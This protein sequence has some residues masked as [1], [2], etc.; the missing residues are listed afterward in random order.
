MIWKRRGAFRSA[1]CLFC[2]PAGLRWGQ[3]PVMGGTTPPRR[4][5]S[6]WIPPAGPRRSAAGRRTCPRELPPPK[7]TASSVF[8]FASPESRLPT[9]HVGPPVGAKLCSSPSLSG[10]D[11]LFVERSRLEGRRGDVDPDSLCS[12]L[13]RKAHQEVL[14]DGD[15][16]GPGAA[17]AGGTQRAV[18]RGAAV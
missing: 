16:V 2:P 14:D 13:G 9:P 3:G 15:R 4:Q 7:R 18:A 1:T 11:D 12:R 8:P 10:G 5:G 6:A 17:P